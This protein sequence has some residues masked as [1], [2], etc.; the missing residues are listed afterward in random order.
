[1][2][3]LEEWMV[4]PC[5]SIIRQLTPADRQTKETSLQDYFEPTTIQLI[6]INLNGSLAAVKRPL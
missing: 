4:E 6:L 1:M 3:E 5:L 2:E